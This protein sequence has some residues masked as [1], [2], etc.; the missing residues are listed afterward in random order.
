M[1]LTHKP[2][3]ESLNFWSGQFLK[4]VPLLKIN[5]YMISEVNSCTLCMSCKLKP[6]LNQVVGM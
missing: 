3:H 5:V 4:P 2:G 6:I 1:E